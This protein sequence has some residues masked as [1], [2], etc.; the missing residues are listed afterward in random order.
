MLPLFTQRAQMNGS[1]LPVAKNRVLV[2]SGFNS[3]QYPEP[4]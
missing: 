2:F 3:W 4:R 1:L